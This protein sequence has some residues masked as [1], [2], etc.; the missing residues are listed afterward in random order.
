MSEVSLSNTR[1]LK[2]KFILGNSFYWCPL[3]TD[4]YLTKN[5]S[6]VINLSNMILLPLDDAMQARPMSSCGVCLCP[7]RSCKTN[8]P[9][10]EFLSPSGS[11]AILDFP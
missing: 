11:Q 2:Y 6:N 4:R 3:V 5:T 9:I 8:K 7:S 10:F 1:T